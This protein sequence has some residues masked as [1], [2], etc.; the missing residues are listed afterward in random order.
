M[1][2]LVIMGEREIPV[3]VIRRSPGR[4]SVRVDGRD[5]E[6]E[7]RGHGTAKVL[8]VDGRDFE[9]MV[10]QESGAEHDRAATLRAVHVRGRTYSV[11]LEDPLRRG[12]RSGPLQQEGRVEVCSVMPGRVSAV[13]VREGEEVVAGQGLIVV[14]AMKMEN[15]IRAPKAGRIVAVDVRTG[16]TVEARAVLI[17]L[18]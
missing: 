6:V 13:L 1:R 4:Y 11:R 9:T 14:E 18:E 12:E 17:S 2:Y 16:E 5:R 10:V 8:T 3:E 15:E 7:S